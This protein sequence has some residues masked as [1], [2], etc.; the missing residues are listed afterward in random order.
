MSYDSPTI[1]II[2]N[3]KYA[4]PLIQSLHLLGI[5]LLLGCTV[6]LNFRLLGIGMRELTM[7]VLAKQLWRWAIGGLVLTML[8]GFFVFLPDPARYAANSAFRFKMALLSAA[9][10]FQFTVF[11]RVIRSDPAASTRWRDVVVSLLSLTMWFCVGWAGRAIA[12]IE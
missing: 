2:R 3:C 10:V 8:S 11:R 4:I 12:F 1:D 5:T 7:P 9:I 6:M